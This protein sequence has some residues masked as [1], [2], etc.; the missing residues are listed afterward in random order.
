MSN[1]IDV[2]ILGATGTVGQEFIAALENHPWFRVTWIAASERSAEK[3]YADAA[4]WQLAREIPHGIADMHVSRCV[5]A[6]SPSL[7]FSALDSAVAGEIEAA[8]A[9]S[10]RTVVSNARNYRMEPDVPLLIPE[11]N[12]DHLGL[13]Q[14]QTETRQWPGKIVTNPNCSTI[15]MTLALAPLCQFGLRQVMVTT[16]QAVSG[17][18]YP[19]VSSLDI[20]GNILP[21]I[22]GEE[23]KMECETPKILGTLV[24][25]DVRPHKV[26]VSAQTTRVPVVSGHTALI[27]VKFNADPTCEELINAFRTYR[28]RPQLEKLPTAPNHPVVYLDDPDRPQPKYDVDREGGMS[29]T[30]GRLRE[31]PVLDYKFIAL[32]HNTVR[33]AAGA[34]I[35]N[36]ELMKIDG[37]L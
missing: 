4:S 26:V 24:D 35:L 30:V 19:G 25:G 14:Q 27:S 1:E 33:G 2:G 16:L 7:I 9:A 12:P 18:G 8:F 10:G 36:A 3:R 32:G 20:L 17:A 34:A 11:I 15:V 23:P 31:C 6:D 29:V 28:G 21:H 13:L 37:L 22:P 5:P